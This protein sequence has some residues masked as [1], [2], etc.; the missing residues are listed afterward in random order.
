MK[1]EKEN[2][3]KEKYLIIRFTLNFKYRNQRIR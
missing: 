3:K 1:K 2:I